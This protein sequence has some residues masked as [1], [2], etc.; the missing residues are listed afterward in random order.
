L[1]I[2][3]SCIL[4]IKVYW[5]RIQGSSGKYLLIDTKWS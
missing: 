2:W 5:A 3:G 4:S 1:S